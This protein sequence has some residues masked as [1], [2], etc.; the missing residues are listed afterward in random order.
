MPLNSI[1]NKPYFRDPRS[2]KNFFELNSDGV[3]ELNHPEL[4]KI[5][6][7]EVDLVV[8][9]LES[10]SFGY[11]HPQGEEERQD[12]FVQITSAS[13]AAEKL[14]MTDLM[15]H[16]VEKLERLAPW[17]LWNTM[18]FACLAYAWPSPHF[19]AQER[20]KDLLATEIAQNFWIYIED[21]HLS[22]TFIQRL[23]DLPELERDINAR[24]QVALNTRLNSEDEGENEHE[25]EEEN[26]N[27]DLYE[28]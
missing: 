22:T 12:C 23:K 19:L 21:E 2:G 7:E 14:G 6:L 13:R 26:E 3:W 10:N 24:R 4:S 11:I 27:F 9:F 20:L 16:I 8:E 15:E 28:D 25:D 5:E 17:D 1:W 18:C